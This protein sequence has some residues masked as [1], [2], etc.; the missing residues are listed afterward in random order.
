MRTVLS[1]LMFGVMSSSA[2]AQPASPQPAAQP[3]IDCRPFDKPPLV[4]VQ[5]GD[6]RTLHATL[7]CLGAEAELLTSGKLSRTP[8]AE[9]AKISEPRDAVWDGPVIGAGLGVLMWALCSGGCD[10]GYMARATVDY[11]LLGLVIDAATSHNKTIY[12][13]SRGPALSFRVR[14]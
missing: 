5:M 8:I 7:T 11:A 14:F 12:K 10:A 9:I 4:N 13:A 2:W 3:A 1:V 6:G